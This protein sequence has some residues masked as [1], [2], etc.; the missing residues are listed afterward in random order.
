VE[1]PVMLHLVSMMKKDK[2]KFQF[3]AGT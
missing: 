2:A 1:V 3:G